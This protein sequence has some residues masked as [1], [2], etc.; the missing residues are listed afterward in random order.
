[1]VQLFR[2]SLFNMLTQDVKIIITMIY[3]VI[4]VFWIHA[5]SADVSEIIIIT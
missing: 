3:T 2:F 4:T 5:Y 1:M